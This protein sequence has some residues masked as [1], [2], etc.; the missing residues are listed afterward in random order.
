MISEDMFQLLK[1]VPRHP[2]NVTLKDLDSLKFLDISLLSN[3][4]DEAVECNYLS[5]SGRNISD[6]LNLRYHLTECGQVALEEFQQRSKDSK[7][8]TW[9]LVIAGLSFIS[10]VIA[11]IISCAQ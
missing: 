7:K 2:G 11:L 3:L 5:R 10:S 8:S 6:I 1:R 9:A 4:L